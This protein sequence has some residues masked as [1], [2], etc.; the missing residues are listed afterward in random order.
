MIARIT[1]APITRTL[2]IGVD[3][4]ASSKSLAKLKIRPITIAAI[5]IGATT[6]NALIISGNKISEMLITHQLPLLVNYNKYVYRSINK[7]P[8]ESS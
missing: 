5:I 7:A 1:M 2:P 8:F 6:A 4:K 3:K